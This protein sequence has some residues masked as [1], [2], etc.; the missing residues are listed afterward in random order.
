VGTADTS[1]VRKFVLPTYSAIQA[2]FVSRD[3]GP[4]VPPHIK[5]EERVSKPIVGPD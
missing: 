5:G 1:E 3:L 2:R 4:F